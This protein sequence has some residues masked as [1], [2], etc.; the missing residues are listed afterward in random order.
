MKKIVFFGAP[1][2]SHL[3]LALGKLL[4]A[5]GQKVLLVDSTTAQSTQGYLPISVER[6]G[7]F[8]TEFEGF[9]VAGGFITFGQLDRYMKQTEGDWPDYDVLVLDTDHAEFVKGEE[10]P[11]YDRRVWCSNFEKLAMRK[12]A[13]LMKR[14]C[15]AESAVKPLPFYKLVSPFVLATVTES[16]IDAGLAPDAAMWLEPVFR[17]PFDERDFAARI[18]DQHHS[19]IDARRLSG[20]YRRTIMSL[21]KQLSGLDE[22][23][24]KAAWKRARRDRRGT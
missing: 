12:N 1:D 22:R 18:D 21:A 15:P 10:L 24:I 23:T 19:R 9:D 7:V 2:K 4:A 14:L 6:P 20:A 17:I 16:Y 11:A 5:A 3:L 8:V 13:E